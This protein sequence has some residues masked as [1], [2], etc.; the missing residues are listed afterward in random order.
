MTLMRHHCT[1]LLKKVCITLCL[2]YYKEYSS[3]SP[4]HDPSMEHLSFAHSSIWWPLSPSRDPILEVS[5]PNPHCLALV[6][7]STNSG[8]GTRKSLTL[9]S[10]GKLNAHYLQVCQFLLKYDSSIDGW[11]LIFIGNSGEER[12]ISVDNSGS[13]LFLN[14]STPRQVICGSPA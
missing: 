9:A 8:R 5:S 11:S 14:I 13:L 2:S 12:K 1:S 6:N 3:S 10:K 4:Y 7:R